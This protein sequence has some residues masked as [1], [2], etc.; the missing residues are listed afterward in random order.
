[1]KNRKPGLSH[2]DERGRIRM[3]DV[4]GKAETARE[5]VAR[6]RIT[7]GRAA[8]SAIRAGRVKKGDPL[9]TA[10]LAGIVAAKRTSDLIPLC[11]PLPLSHV[12]V[13]I[14]REKDGYTIESRVRTTAR[15]GV[16][17]EAL[18]AVAVAALTIYDMLKALDKTMVIGEI[19]V[20][21][22]RGGRSGEY[23]RKAQVGSR[24]APGES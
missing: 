14:V 18:T 24:K 16:E 6:G 1:M 3:V 2:V 11:H 23:S 12:D 22:K 21:E 19:C 9:Q 20:M 7:V 10:R 5:A 15:T 8:L 17:M 4:G 13:D